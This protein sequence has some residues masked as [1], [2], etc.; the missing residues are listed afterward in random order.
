M[1]GIGMKRDPKRPRARINRSSKSHD[2]DQ[3]CY[4]LARQTY[5]QVF[6]WCMVCKATKAQEIHHIKGRVGRG[7][8]KV[9]LLWDFDWFMAVCHYCHPPRGKRHDSRT[10]NEKTIAHRL[11]LVEASHLGE[12]PANLN[13][14]EKVER[15]RIANA[16]R[17]IRRLT[18]DFMVK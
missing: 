16:C 13:P 1:T 7:E 12:Y 10:E 8:N 5:L 4:L 18:D 2:W 14:P 3:W 6:P 15:E 17:E 9:R 11:H